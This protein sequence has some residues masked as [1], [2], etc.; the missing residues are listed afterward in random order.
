MRQT[1]H[2]GNVELN[3]ATSIGVALYPRDG[4][5]VI[6]LMKNADIAMYQAKELGRDNFAFFTPSLNERV[7]EEMNL[8]QDMAD[9][10][11]E[12]QFELYF[13][14]IVRVDTNT[15]MG[16]EAL[17]RWNHPTRGLIYPDKFIP[18][19]ENTGFILKLGRWVIEEGCRIIA[20]FNSLNVGNIKLTVN[21]SSRQFQHSDLANIIHTAMKNAKI[22]ASQFC[23]EV[24]ESV[25]LHNDEKIIKKI[26]DIKSLGVDIAMDDFGTGYSSLSYLHHLHIDTIKIDKSFVDKITSENESSILIDAI[27]SMAKSLNKNVIAEGVECEYQRSYL[28]ENGCQY[29]QGYLF[30]K[31]VNESEYLTMLTQV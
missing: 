28:L 5:T 4:T 22:E 6:D 23:I 11:R 16:A 10:L 27:I 3:V 2:I 26:N 24:T 29:Y 1:W 20:R 15:I 9:A 21:V 13:Q 31:P 19:A 12:K 7:H 14:P 30:S 25:M 8:E 17:I 18:L